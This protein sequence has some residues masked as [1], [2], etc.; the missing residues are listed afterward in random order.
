MDFFLSENMNITCML[1]LYI[2]IPRREKFLDYHSV[3]LLGDL[4]IHTH[5]VMLSVFI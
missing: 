2:V 4:N 1:P 3:I 5:R